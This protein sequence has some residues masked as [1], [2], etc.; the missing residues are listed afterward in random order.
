MVKIGKRELAS[1]GLSSN[2]GEPP[3]KSARRGPQGRASAPGNLPQT[4]TLPAQQLEAQPAPAV[5]ESEATFR[6]QLG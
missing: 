1:L 4:A 3:Q 6:E 5:A 2:V